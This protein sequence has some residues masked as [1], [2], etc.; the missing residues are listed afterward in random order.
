MTA[1]QDPGAGRL[2][3]VAVALVRSLLP[4]AERHEVV[5]EL[6]AEY[7]ERLARHGRA[8][9]RIWVWRQAIGSIPALF[10]RSWWR[11]M[12]GFE[13]Q[14]KPDATG[15]TNVRELDHGFPLRRAGG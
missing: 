11:G 6:E 3:P 15:R 8:R 9:A 1:P 12:T 7:Q 13:P 4:I 2:P 10:A 14:R 5:A